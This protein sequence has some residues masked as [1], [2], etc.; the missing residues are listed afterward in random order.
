VAI[1]MDI[2]RSWISDPTTGN[3][4]QCIKSG[5]LIVAIDQVSESSAFPVPLHTCFFAKK[6]GRN[7]NRTCYPPVFKLITNRSLKV[8]NRSLVLDFNMNLILK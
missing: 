4:F 8:T 2:L 5:D 7:R 1:G 3:P 6:P